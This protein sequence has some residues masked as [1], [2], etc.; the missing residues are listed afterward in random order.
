[1]LNRPYKVRN[2]DN[3]PI[4]APYY[5]SPTNPQYCED[6]VSVSIYCR[7]K[8]GVIEKYLEPTPF[9]AL[10]DEYIISFGDYSNN[11]AA[12][13]FDLSI[14]V[15]VS[16]KNMK[17]GYVIFEY[18]DLDSSV[19][20]GREL[21][22]YPKKQGD[23]A[24][25]KEGDKE[26]IKVSREGSEIVSIT[27]DSSRPN[28]SQIPVLVSHPHLLLLTMPKYS[29][30]GVQSQKILSRDSSP[31]FKVKKEQFVYA[32]VTL[33]GY[34][35]LPVMEPLDEWQ[36]VE[37]YGARWVLG[38]YASTDKHGYAKLVDVLIADEDSL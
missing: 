30:P 9:T 36:P 34:E 6:I 3:M 15:P 28:Q 26:I 2:A 12:A 22:G 16:Y 7:A 38:D 25:T 10:G 5:Q 33:T 8:P 27:L 19:I 23:F 14:T 29:G 35:N 37:V 4:Q 31:D 13:F 1:M 11:T 18:E 24:Y 20:G 21:W 32:D 17:G